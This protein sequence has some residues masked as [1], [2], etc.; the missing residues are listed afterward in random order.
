M[1]ISVLRFAIEKRLFMLAAAVVLFV[2][3]AYTG[4]Q[5]NVDVLPDLN[6]PTVTIISESH[7]LSPAEVETLVTFPIETLMNGMTGVQRVRSV[8]GIGISMVFVEFGWDTPILTARQMVN[9]KLMLAQETLPDDVT[10]QLGPVTSIMGEILLVGVT[11]TDPNRPPMEVRSIADWVIRPRLLTVSGVAQVVPIGGG[12]MQ[13]QVRV[14]PS[15]LRAYDVTLTEVEEAVA[16]SNQNT[17]GGFIEKQSQEYMIRNVGRT[18]KPEDLAEAV[19]TI[20]DGTPI[21][22][23]NVATVEPGIQ[24]KRGDGS[25]NAENA[26]VLNIQKQPGQDTLALTQEILAALDELRGA[27]PADIVIKD[28]LFRQ[29]HFINT[30]I[31][32]LTEALRDGAILV[33]V[34]LSLFLWNTR[35][36]LITIIAIPMSFVIAILA[37]RLFGISINT[38]TLGGLAVAIGEVSDDATIYVENIFRRLKENAAKPPEEQTPTLRVVFDASNEIR[39]SVVFATFIMCVVFIPLFQLGGIEGRIFRPMGLAY[40]FSI[41]ASFLVS[42][43]LTPALAAYLL[44]RVAERQVAKARARKDEKTDQYDAGFVRVLKAIDRVQLR[45]TLRH[46]LIVFGV[47]LLMGVGALAVA[48][49]FG[50]EFLP[51]FNEGSVT[52]SVIAAPGTSLSESNRIGAVAERQIARVPEVVH[53]SRR[54]GRAELDE[55][56]EGVHN[57]EIDVSLRESERSREVILAD[58]RA[59]LDVIPGV[60]VNIGQ[61]ISHRLDHLLSGVNAQVAV[62]VFGDDLDELRARAEDIQREMESIPGVVDVFVEK[63][64]LIPQMQIELDR[65]RAKRYGVRVG[66]LAERL[67]SALYGAK[68]SEV[69]DG[70]QR[71][72]VVV[73]LSEQHRED[74]ESLGGILIDTPSGAKVPLE[75][76]ARVYPTEGPNQ[77]LR[78]NNKRRIVI[79][80]NVSGRDLGSAVQEI[81]Q[82]VSENV[83]LQEGFFVTY[84]GQFE[85]QQDATRVIGSL[86]ILSFL[87]AYLA[88]YNHF[89]VHRVVVGIMLIIPLAFVGAVVGIALTGGVFSVATLMGFI[90]M[91]G[92]AVRNGILQFAHYRHL[93]QNE[94]ESF[95]EEMVI[96]GALE[97]LVPVMMTAVTSILG[98]VPLILAAGEPGKEILYPLA[99][100]VFSGLIGSTLLSVILM[101][102]YFWQFCGPII[103]KLIT[104]PEDELLHQPD[105]P[106]GAKRP[107]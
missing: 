57:S 55:H 60:V 87:I 78:E 16:D 47:F 44:P 33:V 7:G 36:S 18:T 82:R 107:V 31:E 77:I 54:T 22:V 28:D 24:V 99:V 51:P 3:G 84:G 80:C 41:L 72:D 103:P 2:Y 56:A 6:R 73:K 86:S 12:R 13:Y 100:V 102:A 104:D 38:M 45:F 70:Q 52:I 14:D 40:V 64:V 59:Q 43:T 89:R 106:A 9:E 58:I 62:K 8:S 11:S 83:P 48:G 71:I 17:T 46:P 76:V 101:P 30:S 20:R 10:P 53:T 29:E 49:Q 63:Q 93:L 32:N 67:E 19:V 27:L 5:M 69:F 75:S 98:V 26:V 66:H 96:R 105:Y 88:L 42:I 85:S 50:T 23:R 68:V 37:F 81:Q 61:P 34:V 4:S 95:T 92:I 94:G 21:L 15:K 1:L 25:V 65:E 35:T 74:Q 90:T 79:Q 91:T 97:R 39:S